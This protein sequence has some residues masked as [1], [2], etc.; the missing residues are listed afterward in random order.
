MRPDLSTFAKIVAGGMPGAAVAGRKDILDLLDFE[1][2]AGGGAGEDR[3][4]RHLQ[5][6]PGLGRRRHRLPDRARR[7]RRQRRRR[8]RGPRRCGRG[9]NEMLAEEGLPWAAYGTSSGF[10]LFT[11]PARRARY[12]ARELRPH[13]V[14]FG[15][16][17]GADKRWSSACGWPCWWP[18]SMPTRGS[19]ASPRPPTPP[20]TWPTRWRPTARPSACCGPRTNCRRDGR[21]RARLAGRA[22][23][24]WIRFGIVIRA[25]P[26]WSPWD[27]S[28]GRCVRQPCAMRPHPGGRGRGTARWRA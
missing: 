21:R 23:A 14:S 2:A 15:E 16:L 24:G 26:E 10:H 19:A 13:A 17:K 27:G 4:S 12:P 22:A 6:Q 11:N 3:P 28:H 1:A 5:R 8:R 18:G 9:S 25:G 7:D 20:P